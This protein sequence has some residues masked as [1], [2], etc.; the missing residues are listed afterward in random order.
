MHN[1]Q[2]MLAVLHELKEIGVQLS[3]DDFGTG[4]SSL[5]YLKQFP[6]DKLKIDQSFIRDCHQNEED[7]AL[8]STIV[9]LGKNL[10]LSLIAEGVEHIEH[11]DFLTEL[12]CEEIQGYWYSKPLEKHDLLAFLL[13]SNL[14]GQ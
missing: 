7:R 3:I 1:E 4:Y 10:G 11:V 8:V 6:V 2:D 14:D 12:N 13:A 9:S 5:S